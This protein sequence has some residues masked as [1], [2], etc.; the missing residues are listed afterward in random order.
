MMIKH[1]VLG[2]KTKDD[3]KQKE[4]DKVG[5]RLS[6]RFKD[7]TRDVSLNGYGH[8]SPIDATMKQ[9][10]PRGSGKPIYEMVINDIKERAET[11][12]E[13]YGEPLKA[14]NGRKPLV[15]MYQEMLDGVQYL[16]QHLVE[17]E[18]TM[19]TQ[20]YRQLEESGKDVIMSNIGG[21]T[22]CLIYKEE[23]PYG[24]ETIV[25]FKFTPD[26]I[27]LADVKVY[28]GIRSHKRML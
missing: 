22:P 4:D 16:K 26:G 3:M 7:Y 13:K 25:E 19:I 21:F 9:P 8:D 27:R 5:F 6:K 18:E 10:K 12:R 14:N 15:D 20:M 11:G 23:D 2:K 17:E 28:S 24:V 1:Y